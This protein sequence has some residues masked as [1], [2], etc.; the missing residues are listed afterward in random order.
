[1]AEIACNV[2]WVLHVDEGLRVT[3]VATRRQTTVLA[4]QV[5]LAA[6]HRLMSASQREL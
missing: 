3:V 4:V 1:M 5:T 6:Q 2:V